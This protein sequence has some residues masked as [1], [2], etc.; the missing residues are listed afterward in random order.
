MTERATTQEGHKD[1]AHPQKRNVSLVLFPP[2]S[3]LN[4]LR[5]IVR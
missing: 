1:Q 2:P 5:F 4:F 3:K